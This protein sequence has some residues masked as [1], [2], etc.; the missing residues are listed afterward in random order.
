MG[1]KQTDVLIVGA[2]PAGLAAA[3]ELKQN[4]VANVTV[5]DRE[6][7]AGGMPRL[8][9]H[10]G[11]GMADFRRIY[12]GPNYA[13]RHVQRAVAAGVNLH[14][15]TTITGWESAN[16]L[17]YTSP[18]GIGTISAKAIL[19]ATGVRE[20]ARAARMTAGTRP[21]GI[22]TTGSLQRFVDEHHLPVGKR[23]VIVGAEEVS[24]SAFMTLRGAG[25]DIVAITTELPHHQMY[26]P[27]LPAK[28]GLIDL[29]HRT[30]VHTTTRIR[31]VLG[32]KRVEGVEIIHADSGKVEIVAC[33]TL[34]FTGKW[35]PEHEVARTGGLN[36]DQGTLG[37]QIDG[38]LRTSLRGVFAAGNLLRGA[39]TAGTSAMEGRWAAQSIG[40]FLK[41]R[42][43]P[44][45]RVAIAVAAPL[46]W[47]FPNWISADASPSQLKQFSL[48][49]TQFVQNATIQVQQGQKTLYTQTFRR[50]RPNKTLHLSSQWL[51]QVDPTGG[52]LRIIVDHPL[53]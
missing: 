30:P 8:C 47:V 15:A 6:P 24:L 38:Q 7:E 51:T 36:I 44:Q 29:L 33:D 14:T 37:P 48:R 2:G 11:F 12:T 17:T 39:E 52:S 50:L 13:R 34:I 20:R 43:W 1:I 22:F 3:I 10:T 26:F 9:H 16:A 41:Q 49:V 5:V 31:R 42:T 28:W 45:Q 4:G 46:K 40:R 27:Y 35:I 19:L 32:R 18:Q 23:A 53:A 21:A 25:L